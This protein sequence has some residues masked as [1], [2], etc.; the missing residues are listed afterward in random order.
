M[1]M[2]GSDRHSR[3]VLD[4]VPAWGVTVACAVKRNAVAS[5]DVVGFQ[6]IQH[7]VHAVLK[8]AGS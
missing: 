1:T 2:P 8:H 5:F 7:V 3:P 4:Q 6:E